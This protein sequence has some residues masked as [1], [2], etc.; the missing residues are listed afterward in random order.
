MDK[1]HIGGVIGEKGTTIMH[2]G[3][4]ASNAESTAFVLDNILIKRHT[5]ARE[6]ILVSKFPKL[7]TFH[8]C[9]AAGDAMHLS[10]DAGSTKRDIEG[11]RARAGIGFINLGAV[12]G[13]GRLNELLKLM[14]P[15][16]IE[17]PVEEEEFHL[18]GGKVK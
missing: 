13:A 6:K 12:K 15:K 5:V 3:G 7:G 9:G 8:V 2:G 4:I 11:V 17:S 14:H 1:D 16:I 10:Q 18:T